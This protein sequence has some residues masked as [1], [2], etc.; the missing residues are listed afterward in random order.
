MIRTR[1]VAI[2]AKPRMVNM[3]GYL[4]FAL[5]HPTWGSAVR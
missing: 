3:N 4:T 2:I 1:K 5:E